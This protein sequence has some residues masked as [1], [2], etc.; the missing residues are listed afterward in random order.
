MLLAYIFNGITCYNMKYAKQ[1]YH[2]NYNVLECKI[3]WK[4]KHTSVNVILKLTN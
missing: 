2:F 1:T 3:L 4:V